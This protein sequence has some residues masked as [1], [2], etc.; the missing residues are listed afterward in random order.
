[1]VIL[2]DAEVVAELMRPRPD[3]LLQAWFRTVAG[4]DLGLST[5]SLARLH[6][7]AARVA[8]PAARQAVTGAIEQLIT[9]LPGRIFPFDLAATGVF[10][11]LVQR[12]EAADNGV[13]LTVYDAL[14][15][16]TALG[17]DADLASGRP[18]AFIGT[19][20]R[21]INPFA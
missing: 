7:G 11:E 10:S 17:E 13:P 3:P 2:M 9:R 8:E 1:M 21:L 18:R 5:V 6:L 4:S 20:V 16:S 19:G 15:A 12:T 14:V